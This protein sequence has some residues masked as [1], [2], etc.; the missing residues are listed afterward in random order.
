MGCIERRFVWVVACFAGLGTLLFGYCTGVI[1]PVLVLIGQEQTFSLD[2]ID[3]TLVVSL[4]VA[5]AIL[6][7]IGG[8]PIATQAGRRVPILISS[9]LFGAG[10]ISSALANSV[11]VLIAGRILTG[12]AFGL[13]S[14]SVPLYSAEVAPASLRGTLVILSVLCCTIGQFLAYVAGAVF[15]FQ[16]GW[17][18]ALGIA[19]A[20]S[21]LLFVAMLF[22]P[23]S[24]RWLV[25]KKRSHQAERVLQRIRGI[26]DVCDELRH[27]EASLSEEHGGYGELFRHPRPL[28]VGSILHVLQQF[29]GINAVLYYAPTLLNQTSLE[30]SDAIY[31]SMA[32]A[33]CNVLFTIVALFLVERAGRRILLLV[34]LVGACAGQAVLGVCFLVDSNP[35]VAL[36]ALMIFVSFY[37]IG[38]GNIP[39]TVNSEI[40]PLK[41]RGLGNSVAAA[42]NWTS[43]LIVSMT[44]LPLSGAITF[45]GVALVFATICLIGTVVVYLFVPET[46]GRSLEEIQ[47]IFRGPSI[48]W[49]IRPAIAIE[50][51]DSGSIATLT[52]AK[53]R[54][55]ISA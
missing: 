34:S 16:N 27:I 8:G 21:V 18:W 42:V 38:L 2:D 4:A 9:V 53:Y 24:P 50:N 51:P 47:S 52:V 19:L 33:G 31:F 37:A 36:V 7:A 49:G 35:V 39:W 29:C 46:K 45:G 23:E 1:G 48:L 40:Y 10:S 43:N 20:P 22:L 6:G 11:G 30:A 13:A 3:K 44:F 14:F 32:V 26:S 54:A 55:S 5:G 25:Q 41:I 17:R 15:I 12:I 28:I